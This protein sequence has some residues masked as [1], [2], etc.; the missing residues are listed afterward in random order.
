M[1]KQRRASISK[2]LG[3][4]DMALDMIRDAKY[5]EQ[6]VLDNVPENL[7]SGDRYEEIENAVDSLEDAISSMEE[8]KRYIERAIS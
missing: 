4:L 3:Y 8:A 1:N 6:D 5:E 7:Q 2:A